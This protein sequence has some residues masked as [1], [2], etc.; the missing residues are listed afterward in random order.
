MNPLFQPATLKGMTLRNRFVR[1]ATWEAMA[2]PRGEVTARL[3]E[4]IAA[5]A[6]GG[7][8]LII[9][10]HAFVRP[11]GQA[12]PGQIGVYDD[13][14]IPG[15][16]RLADAAHAHGAAIL[17]QLAHAG[18]FADPA[19]TGMPPLAV[20]AAVRL[21][22]LERREIEEAEIARLVEAFARAAGRAR[23]AG[24]D[25]VQ[26]H[27]AHGYL[28]NQ[29]LSPLFNRRADAYGGTIE[30]RCRIHGEII[31][32]IR[33]QVGEDYPV[34]VKLNGRDFADGGLGAEEAAQAAARLEAAG[35]DGIEVSSGMTR[36]ARHGSARKGIARP[37]EE[38]YNRSDAEVIRRKVRVPL[39][40]VG[41]IR[42]PETAARLLA[43]G[44]CDFIAMSR[45]FIRE[46]DL[47]RRWQS[48]DLRPAACVSDNLCYGPARSG[49]GL[50]C[51]TAARE[52]ERKAP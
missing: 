13:R 32:A 47:V 22:D 34:L 38:A 3:E 51:V 43:E 14:L 46:P 15:L 8:G 35:V 10:S 20:S 33:R 7:V 30:N 31:A 50:Y 27:A 12:G 18:Y 44:V 49:E 2:T 11:E 41:G 37:E 23:Q 5:L 40:L 48:G 45:P 39:V 6:R 26:L 29:F 24:F 42:S 16:R 52:Q 17:L 4:T 21:D 9:S 36:H 25:G 28:L 1:S 19:L